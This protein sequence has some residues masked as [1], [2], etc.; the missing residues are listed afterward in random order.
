MPVAGL[1]AGHASTAFLDLAARYPDAALSVATGG[2]RLPKGTG[3]GSDAVAALG[4]IPG[5]VVVNGIVGAAGLEP[6]LAG[7]GAGN[8]VALANKESLVTGGPLVLDALTTRGAELIPV[9][10]EHSAI[11]QCLAGEEQGLVKR[12]VLTASGGPFR[13]MDRDA[14]TG[15]TVD[16]ALAHPTWDMG[17]RI[18]IDSATLMNKAFEVIE[19]HFLF[20]L[21]FD[22]IEVVVHPQSFVHALVE[23]VD[24]VVK[25]EVGPPD[26]RKP[27]QVA[28]THPDRAPNSSSRFELSDLTFAEPDRIAFPALDLGY[29]AGR[30]GGNAPAVLNAADE[31]AVS[32]F[33]EGRIPFTA[34]TEVVASSLEAVPH[35]ALQRLEDAL[36]ADREGRIAAAEAVADRSR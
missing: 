12:V 26:M 11:W 28:L 5:S 7:L 9:D 31:V 24:G 6:T 14:L 30:L 33:L 15:V 35:Q 23:F 13:G 8:R 29:A 21:E 22:Q 18:T 25:A 10:S 36:D 3:V 34:I 19:A 2:D 20:G 16:Q 1:A 4:A 32:A 17:D 27:I